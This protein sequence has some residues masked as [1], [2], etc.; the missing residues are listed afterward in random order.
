MGDYGILVYAGFRRRTALLYNFAAALSVVLGG[1]FAIYFIETVAMVSGF[2]IAFSA[3][4]FFY[5]AASELIPEL[6][7]QR[8]FKRSVLQFVIFILGIVLIWSLN[9]IFPE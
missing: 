1:L 2:L 3:G 8:D 7:K 6:H 9:L 4:G 5:L